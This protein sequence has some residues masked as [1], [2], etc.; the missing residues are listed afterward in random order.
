MKSLIALLH[1]ASSTRSIHPL[2]AGPWISGS[3]ADEQFHGVSTIEDLK[4]NFELSTLFYAFISPLI[5]DIVVRIRFVY[6][7]E[8]R[9]FSRFCMV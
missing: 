9:E 3:A 8:H 1:A 4:T 2:L 5:V 6:K 7:T